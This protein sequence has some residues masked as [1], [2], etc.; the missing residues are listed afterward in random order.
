MHILTIGTICRSYSKYSL[1]GYKF[2][3]QNKALQYRSRLHPAGSGRTLLSERLQGTLRERDPRGEDGSSY[4]LG[5]SVVS[6]SIFRCPS[7]WLELARMRTPGVHA[8]GKGPE[9]FVVPT[10]ASIRMSPSRSAVSY[11]WAR[12]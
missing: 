7:C 5:L 6:G 1:H 12:K 9:L 2:Y 8:Q 4:S 10:D 3:S 11:T